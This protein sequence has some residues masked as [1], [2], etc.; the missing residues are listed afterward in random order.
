MPCHLG[1]LHNFQPTNQRRDWVQLH[2]LYFISENLLVFFS[3]VNNFLGQLCNLT[4]SNIMTPLLCVQCVCMYH[5]SFY[6]IFLKLTIDQI[7]K[8]M[9]IFIKYERIFFL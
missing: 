3:F 9:T 7:V 6:L 4:L 8:R 5:D 1:K 2:L